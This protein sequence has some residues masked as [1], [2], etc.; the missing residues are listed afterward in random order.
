MADTLEVLA[1]RTQRGPIVDPAERELWLAIRQARIVEA[2][3]IGRALGLEPVGAV[4]HEDRP[5]KK[6]R[7]V[8]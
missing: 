4:K 8:A 1:S 7:P 5:R 2:N 6:K 3:A